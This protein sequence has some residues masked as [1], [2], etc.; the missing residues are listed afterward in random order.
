MSEYLQAGEFNP[1]SEQLEE[2]YEQY[3]DSRAIEYLGALAAKKCHS[4]RP[5]GLRDTIGCFEDVH[6]KF[7]PKSNYKTPIAQEFRNLP[8]NKE[9]ICRT[10]HNEQHSTNVIPEKPSIAEMKKAINEHNIQ[11]V[12][13]RNGN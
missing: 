4:L 10:V 11:E 5:C 9:K 3:I 7:W 2:Y 1:T 12:L 13:N 6:H 8:E